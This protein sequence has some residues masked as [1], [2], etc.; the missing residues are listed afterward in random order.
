[1][2]IINFCLNIFRAS[3]CPKHVETEVNNKHLIVASF[4]F[5]LFIL[6]Q[7]TVRMFSEFLYISRT[8]C[9]E[10]LHVDPGSPAVLIR[11]ICAFSSLSFYCN[12]TYVASAPQTA[13][14]WSLVV[15]SGISE[16]RQCYQL[17][18]SILQGDP[19]LMDITAV[20]DFVGLRDQKRS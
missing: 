7:I 11:F 15:Q 17:L 16:P 9:H 1:M 20:D 13:S 18:H 14:S 10:I 4:W 12:S 6:C 2:F 5:S 19:R 8:A 3:L